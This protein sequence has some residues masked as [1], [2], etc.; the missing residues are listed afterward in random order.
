MNRPRRE[1]WPGFQKDNSKMG[2]NKCAKAYS[3]KT[4]QK[5]RLHHIFGLKK[6]KTLL[7]TTIGVNM[8]FRFVVNE[9]S[10]L[11]CKLRYVISDYIA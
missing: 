6:R 5:K 4:G 3:I 9:I 2:L 11:E 8:L 1:N 10:Q 7:I